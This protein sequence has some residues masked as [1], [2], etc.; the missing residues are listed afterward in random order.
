MEQLLAHIP[1]QE[2]SLLLPGSWTSSFQ[3]RETIRFCAPPS[4]RHRYG[5]PGKLLSFPIIHSRV[6][7]SNFFNTWT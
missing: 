4:V 5:S 7:K 3:N 2:A 6:L 1:Q